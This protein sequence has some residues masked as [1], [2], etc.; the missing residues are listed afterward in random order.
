MKLVSNWKQWPQW[1]SQ[2]FIIL[3]FVA[4]IVLQVGSYASSTG[5][6]HA[7]PYFQWVVFPCLALAFIGRI[8]KQP[9]L[10][11]SGDKVE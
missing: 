11:A 2:R 8:V 4:E 9:K 6:A 7:I 10:E 5:V 3:A 1:H